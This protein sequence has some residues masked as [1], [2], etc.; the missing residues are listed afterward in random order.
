MATKIIR[1]WEDLV[2]LESE[3]YKLDIDLVNGCGWINPKFEVFETNELSHAYY[4]STHTFYGH[5]Y[6]ASTELL[7]K[8]GFDVKLLSWDSLPTK[9]MLAD[10]IEAFESLSAASSMSAASLDD[11][12]DIGTIPD[13]GSARYTPKRSQQIKNKRRKRR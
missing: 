13:A 9:A 6:K 11:L 2:G 5:N 7:R 8:C 1:N 10:T 4:L 3:H 12:R